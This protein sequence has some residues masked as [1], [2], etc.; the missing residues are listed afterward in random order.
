MFAIYHTLLIHKGIG[1]RSLDQIER[2]QQK[3]VVYLVF[4]KT[5]KKSHI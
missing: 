1:T 4:G 5:V 3:S 2:I